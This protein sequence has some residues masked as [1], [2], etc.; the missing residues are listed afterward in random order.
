MTPAPVVLLTF[1]ICGV[2]MA[3]S[4]FI[5]G[6]LFSEAQSLLTDSLRDIAE[7]KVWRGD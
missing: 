7:F 1:S 2:I 4:L 3:T 6:S 5:I